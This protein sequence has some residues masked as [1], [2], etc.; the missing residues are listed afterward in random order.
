MIFRFVDNKSDS[1]YVPLLAQLAFK[2]CNNRDGRIYTTYSGSI[3]GKNIVEVLIIQLTPIIINKKNAIIL[4][5]LVNPF[6][7]DLCDY[8]SKNREIDYSKIKLIKKYIFSYLG[9]EFTKKI[10]SDLTV[11]GAEIYI[12]KSMHEKSKKMLKELDN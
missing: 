6:F 7:D 12:N 4:N 9:D 10:Y 8:L 1:S 3:I 11:E 5:L 2:Y